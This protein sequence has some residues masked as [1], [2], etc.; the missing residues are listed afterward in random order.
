MKLF[1][2]LVKILYI[3]KVLRMSN[4]QDAMSELQNQL[5]FAAAGKERE[6]LQ[7]ISKL[8]VTIANLMH[9]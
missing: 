9:K 6:L 4:M 2:Y 3:N 5:K 1:N 7:T 8:N